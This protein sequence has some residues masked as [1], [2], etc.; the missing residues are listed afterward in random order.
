[1]LHATRAVENPECRAGKS[2]GI[3][4]RC[5]EAE[6]RSGSGIDGRCDCSDCSVC[7]RRESDTGRPRGDLYSD[8]LTVWFQ[9]NCYINFTMAATD[10]ANGPGDIQVW[11]AWYSADNEIT[12]EPKRKE[13]RQ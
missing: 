12:A 7:G 8:V 2:K 10:I 3:R 6:R 4:A 11:D 13:V 9:T 1:M 5:G